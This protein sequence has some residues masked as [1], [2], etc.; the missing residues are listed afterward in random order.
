[1]RSRILSS[2]LCA[3][4]LSACA[5]TELTPSA[6][7]V[8]IV[9]QEPQGCKYLGEV[10][11]NQGN[12]FTGGFTSNANLETGARNDMKN[13]AQKLGGNTVQMLTNRAGQTGSFGQG[14]GAMEQTNVTY[15]GIAYSCPEAK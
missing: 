9:T 11:G 7:E 4:C 2:I 10:T 3:L 5:A 6:Q 1:M 12:A 15:S 14:S 13:Q 8:R